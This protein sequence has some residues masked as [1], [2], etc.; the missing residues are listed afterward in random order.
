MHEINDDG[1]V[2][3]YIDSR[4]WSSGW[5]IAVYYNIGNQPYMFFL[6]RSNGTVDIHKLHH[7]RM[8]D[9]ESVKENLKYGDIV[10]FS[11]DDP[12]SNFLQIPVGEWSHVGI[13][14]S[15]ATTHKDVQLLES[16]PSTGVHLINLGE[17]IKNYNG[18]VSIRHLNIYRT[19]IMKKDLE[20]FYEEVK[21]R[22]YEKDLRELANATIDYGDK[23]GTTLNKEDLS[24]FFC[25]ELVAEAYQ[26]LGLL[27]NNDYLHPSNEY[28]PKDFADI[29]IKLL[30]G[31]LLPEVTIKYV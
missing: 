2:G 9:Y 23:Y 5:S 28:L 16:I 20:H 14:Y 13:V 19:S 11:G 26:R 12:Q 7:E 21:N 29:N 22:K 4:D 18:R 3:R 31:E 8:V 27:S 17:K 25:S 1:T 10:L 15:E 30:K 24:Q 6:K